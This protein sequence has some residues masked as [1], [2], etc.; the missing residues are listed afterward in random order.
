M[1]GI[2]KVEN[3]NY[4]SQV[5]DSALRKTGIADISMP[6]WLILL[7]NRGVYNAKWISVNFTFPAITGSYITMSGLV[8]PGSEP[9]RHR[10]LGRGE[11]GQFH[12]RRQPAHQQLQD[13]DRGLQQRQQLFRRGEQHAACNQYRV[14]QD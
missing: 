9:R 8:S 14:E 11:H 4:S 1:G 3:A 6:E 12:R 2:S 5:S 13:H 10:R 7:K